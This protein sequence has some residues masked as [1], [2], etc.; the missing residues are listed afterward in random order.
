[1]P[2]L[3]DKIRITIHNGS[4]VTTSTQVKFILSGRHV[5]I[6]HYT[7]SYKNENRKRSHFLKYITTCK[8]SVFYVQC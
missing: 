6:L 2:V 1:M 7:L 4:S 5:G 8:I 3:L